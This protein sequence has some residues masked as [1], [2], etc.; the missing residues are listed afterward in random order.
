MHSCG[1][2]TVTA[3]ICAG[4]PPQLH[5]F[6]RARHRDCM[7]SCGRATATAC[8][9]ARSGTRS[10]ARAWRHCDCMRASAQW[11]KVKRAGMAPGARSSFAMIPF[12]N[13]AYV[14]GG[15]SDNECRVRTLCGVRLRDRRLSVCSLDTNSCLAK[16]HLAC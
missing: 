12:K 11:D 1:R 15:V 10:S 13:R 5:A 4:A 2:A 9:Q 16:Q 6:M 3:C 14:F 8:V 7:H